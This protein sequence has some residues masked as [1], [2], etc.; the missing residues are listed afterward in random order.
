VVI[1]PFVGYSVRGSKPFVQV[2]RGRPGHQEA[3]RLGDH[4]EAARGS[5]ATPSDAQPVSVAD[6]RILVS[7][8]AALGGSLASE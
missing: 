2:P 8:A 5:R 7:N 3:L 4:L 6:P 1:V